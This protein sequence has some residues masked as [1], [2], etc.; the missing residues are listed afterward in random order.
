[1]SFLSLR[2]LAA[3]LSVSKE[4][5]AAVRSMRPAMLTA[6]IPSDEFAALCSSSTLRRHV[7]RLGLMDEDDQHNLSL[8]FSELPTLV[9]A[10]P[11][12]QSLSMCVGM[13]SGATQWMLPP[14]LQHLDVLLSDSFNDNGQAIATALLVSIGQLHQLHTLRFQMPSRKG[15][16]LV[17][18]QQLPLLRNLDLNVSFPDVKQ[19][20]VDLCALHRLHRLHIDT[21]GISQEHCA[22]LFTTLLR[23]VPEEELQALQWREFVIVE[24]PFTDELTPLLPRLPSLERLAGNFTQCIRFDFLAAIPRLLHLELDLAGIRGNAWTNLLVAF[25]SDGLTRLH[26]LCLY[27]GPCSSEDLA[28]LLSHTPS[29]TSLV[30]DEL[31]SVASLSFFRQL[32]KLAETLTHL[33]LDC[34]YLWHLTAADLPPLFE[35]Q[36]LRT[37]RLL[38][39]PATEPDMLTAANRAPLEQRPCSVLPR[40][41]VFEWTT[42]ASF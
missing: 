2:E 38:R 15:P 20:A 33:T 17:A 13:D 41:E 26:A 1:M 42:R 32:P 18:L 35:L 19:F 23:D 40:L 27:G 16:P 37:L 7:G 8:V 10:L 30:L 21:W 25:T 36:Q 24:L 31:Q 28:K 14:Q 39:W 29:L 9:H 12:L 34:S 22:A 5:T 3:A 11:Q 4:W 6:D